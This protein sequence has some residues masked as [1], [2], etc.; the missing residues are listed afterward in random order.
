MVSSEGGAGVKLDAMLCNYAETVNNLLYLSGGGI[1]T[2]EIPSGT[3]PYALNLGFGLIVTVPPGE[4][5]KSHDLYIELVDEHDQAV[6]L[7]RA[8]G[9]EKPLKVVIN[10]A[11]DATTV[12][13]ADD[14]D[15]TVALA[16]NLQGLPLPDPGRY[17]FVLSIGGQELRRLGLRV[18]AHP[19]TSQVTI[20]PNP[21]TE[22]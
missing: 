22:L 6:A 13:E 16:A 17:E 3:P 14:D 11:V 2:T 7:P 5:G 9:S 18:R 4:V 20:I 15:Q 8:D 1:N 21:S 19:Q 12:L 10:F